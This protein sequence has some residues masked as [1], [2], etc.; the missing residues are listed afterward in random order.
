[1][2]WGGQA[3]GS[4]RETDAKK[5][6]PIMSAE[7]RSLSLG[8]GSASSAAQPAAG[9]W[10]WHRQRLKT[11]YGLACCYCIVVGERDTVL[12]AMSARGYSGWCLR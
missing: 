4:C 5:P 11:R 1:M 12:R 2:R 6:V 9:N 10:P 3:N 7:G 8:R